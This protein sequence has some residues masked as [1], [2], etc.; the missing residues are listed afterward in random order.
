MSSL[1][2]Q[3]KYSPFLKKM[4]F[5]A[6]GGIFLD[7][8]ILVMIGIALVQLEPKLGL[9][10]FWSGLSG[11]ASLMGILFG[12]LIFGYVTDLIGRKMMYMID[13]I[14]II[15]L[16]ILSMFINSA[17]ELVMLR[18]A[19]GLALGADYP[20]STSL[21]AEFSP[22]K[23]RGF[24]LGIMMTLWYVGAIVSSFVGYLFLA[25]PNGW[26]WMLGSAAIPALILVIGRFDAPESPRWLLKSGR[27]EEALQVAKRVWGEKAELSDLDE[28]PKKTN[29]RLL[30]QKGYLQR[31]LFAG[32]FWM[33]QVIPCF[34]IYTFGPQILGAFG[35]S[36]GNNWIWGYAAIN[37]A[38]AIGCIPGLYWVESMGRRRMV[39][40]SFTFMTL[41]LLLL[42][43]MGKPPIWIVVLGFGIYAFFSGP[44]T[45]L[46]ALYP[47]ELFPTEIRA[48]AYGIATAISRIGAAIGTFAL[49]WVLQNWGV[50]NTML[51]A[52]GITLLGLIVCLLWA[53]ETK[54]KTLAECSTLDDGK[55]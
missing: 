25:F 17:I 33:F 50:R 6:G 52:T 40:M 4:T 13:L 53:P 55:G 7:G 20:I 38:F 54:G 1:V 32:L 14:A 16:S 39:I 15:I 41:G 11:A 49:P 3:S 23:H 2:E 10:S 46:D 45:V 18:F 27:A 35:M 9:D 42:G 48:S 5:F 12:G 30:F 31:L 34:A 26:A 37:F 19:I 21:L 43:L 24:M 29:T 51:L 28:V 36:D 22:T 8:Y 47:N 44:A